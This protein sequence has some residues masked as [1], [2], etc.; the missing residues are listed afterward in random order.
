MIGPEMMARL[1][2]NQLRRDSY[3]LASLAHAALQD[4]SHALFSADLSYIHGFTFV[5]EG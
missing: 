1:R 3:A 5:G 4:I 2:I